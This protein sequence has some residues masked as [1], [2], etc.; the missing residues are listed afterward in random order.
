MNLTNRKTAS[1][2]CVLKTFDFQHTFLTYDLSQRGLCRIR[3]FEF[4]NSVTKDCGFMSA[5]KADK[6][7]IVASQDP[8]SAGSVTNFAEAIATEVCLIPSNSQG[9]SSHL[10][11]FWQGARS[12]PDT[13]WIEHYP[14]GTMLAPRQERFSIVAFQTGPDQSF[15]NPAW[16]EVSHLFIEELLLGRELD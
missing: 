8:R 12:L 7:V 3:I 10:P 2:A 16:R 14:P 4:F 15:Y 13:V 1:R 6:T 9:K 5:C 11:P